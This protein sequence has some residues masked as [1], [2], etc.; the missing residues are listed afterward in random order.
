MHL[1]TVGEA[2]VL[3]GYIGQLET[4]FFE[5]ALAQSV[6]SELTEAASY[7]S[8]DAVETV[9]G[10]EGIEGAGE[11]LLA[12]NGPVSHIVGKVEAAAQSRQLLL[13][14]LIVLILSAVKQLVGILG[15]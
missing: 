9:V 12:A 5:Q 4:N 6:A 14:F 11:H 3:V 10:L 8:K 7:V 1:V 15:E 13:Y 2:G